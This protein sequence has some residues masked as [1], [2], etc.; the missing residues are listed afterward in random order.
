MFIKKVYIENFGN[1]SEKSFILDKGI[2]QFI[3]ENGWGKSTLAV[4]IKAMLYGLEEKGKRKG[5]F[6]REHYYPW[7]NGRFGG[8]IIIEQEG[9]NYKITRYFGFQK[10]SEDTLEVLNL[11]SNLSA[12]SILKCSEPGIFFLGI[13]KESFERSCFISL[14]KSPEITDSINAKLNNLLENGDDVGNYSK[15][16]EILKN[17][18]YEYKSPRGLGLISQREKR[19]AE[20]NEKLRVLET[21]QIEYDKLKSIEKELRTAVKKYSVRKNLLEKK[22]ESFLLKSK[23][24]SKKNHIKKNII[25]FLLFD[26]C[27]LSGIV[28]FHLFKNYMYLICSCLFA[29]AAAMTVLLFPSKSYKKKTK[30]KFD[31]GM[32]KN[33]CSLGESDE[34][35]ED[36][37]NQ[38]AEYNQKIVYLERELKH[39][40]DN[41]ELLETEIVH[42]NEYACELENIRNSVKA[43]VS[44]YNSLLETQDLLKEAYENLSGR[45]MSKM[46]AAF[47]KYASKITDCDNFFIDQ[48]LNVN[49][50]LKGNC[51]KSDFFS[52]GYKDL[53]NFFARLALVDSMFNQEDVFLVLDDPFVNMDQEKIAIAGKILEEISSKRQ[54]LYFTCH[55]S[56]K[57]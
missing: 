39:C 17:A 27:V 33:P 47:K 25:V 8:S 4:F 20:L 3:Y 37:N 29:T 48:N 56:R 7:N 53:M 57:V 44:V 50:D 16:E 28:F 15:A 5:F 14:N 55:T 43:S 2:N 38:I 34:S 52:S 10:K 32:Y 26:L 24:H 11:E 1:I 21:K 45:Y 46:K 41:L 51:K 40:E 19:L 22:K 13:D 23:N 36:I 6:E 42:K 30:N 49:Y 54:I 12:E 9:K 31:Y 18:I 35:L